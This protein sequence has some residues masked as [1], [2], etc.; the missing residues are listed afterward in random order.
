MNIFSI[1]VAFIVVGLVFYIL[2]NEIDRSGVIG[3]VTGG[4][5]S[6]TSDSSSSKNNNNKNNTSNTLSEYRSLLSILLLV[7]IVIVL[8]VLAATW[9]PG[10]SSAVDQHHHH[11]ATRNQ[12]FFNLIQLNIDNLMENGGNGGTNNGLSA[13]SDIAR[14][15]A[16]FDHARNGN[17]SVPVQADGWLMTE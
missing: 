12:I 17:R 13:D 15:M 5:L 1:I 10:F 11:L 9:L 3:E 2:Q 4:V 14:A 6:S 16:E 8:L 7:T